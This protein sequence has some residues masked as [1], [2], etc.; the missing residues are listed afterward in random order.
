MVA[1][2]TCID[3]TSNELGASVMLNSILV[4]AS[5]AYKRRAVRC[6]CVQVCAA[7]PVHAFDHG[8]SF[9]HS[10]RIFSHDIRPLDTVKP[11]AVARFWMA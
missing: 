10:S 11:V 1:V 5:C 6:R 4:A 3:E 9:H 8:T 7:L 2:L